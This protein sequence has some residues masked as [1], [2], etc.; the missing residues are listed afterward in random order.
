MFSF[1]L[2]IFKNLCLSLEN[3]EIKKFSKID[4]FAYLPMLKP[5]PR[6]LF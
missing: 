1:I 4:D 3:F 5:S 2:G 6:P